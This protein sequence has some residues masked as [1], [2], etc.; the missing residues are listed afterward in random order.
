MHAAGQRSWNGVLT[1]GVQKGVMIS[2]RNV[3]ANTLQLR[4]FESRRLEALRRKHGPKYHEVVLGLLPLSHIYALIAI[5][6]SQVFQGAK[7]V[8][9][10][11]F[12]IK[13]YLQAL[14]DYQVKTLYVVSRSKTI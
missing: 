8:I 4:A 13:S 7:V 12:E 14:Q 11:K 6:H 3:I 9:L 10:P 1:Q 2:H 5:A